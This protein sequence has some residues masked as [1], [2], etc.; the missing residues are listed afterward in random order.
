LSKQL[1]I[2][3]RKN[4]EKSINVWKANYQPE[5]SLIGKPRKDE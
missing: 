1:L 4:S 5:D 3:Q 2:L